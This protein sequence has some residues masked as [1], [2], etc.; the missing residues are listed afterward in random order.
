MQAPDLSPRT[1]FESA[2]AQNLDAK[3]AILIGVS[4]L[5]LC[6]VIAMTNISLM[7]DTPFNF[8]VVYEN[9]RDFVLHDST[10]TVEWYS[11]PVAFKAF[12][13]L[14]ALE[15]VRRVDGSNRNTPRQFQQMRLML[16]AAQVQEVLQKYPRLPTHVK[17]WLKV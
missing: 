6:L 12:E 13:Y 5:E 11:K 8:E 16:E 15:L 2:T 7:Q 10:K 9:Y 1:L 3:A 4:I 14:V 17:G